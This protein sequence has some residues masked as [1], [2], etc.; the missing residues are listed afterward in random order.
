MSN[1][2]PVSKITLYPITAAIWR[3]DNAKS[4][5]YSVTFHRTYKDDNGKWQSTDSFGTGELLLLAKVADQAHTEICRLR[6]DR[7]H[8]ADE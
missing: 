3:N 5:S 2:K 4:E 6:A 8:E 7:Q 1:N